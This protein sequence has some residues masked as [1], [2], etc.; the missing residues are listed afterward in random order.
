MPSSVARQGEPPSLLI[1]RSRTFV[2]RGVGRADYQHAETRPHAEQEEQLPD[3]LDDD[4]RLAGP[5]RPL[6]QRQV[7]TVHGHRDRTPFASDRFSEVPTAGRELDHAREL[8]RIDQRRAQGPE[9][10]RSRREG[11]LIVAGPTAPVPSS[12]RTP[13]MPRPP[14]ST[15]CSRD[16][17]GPVRGNIRPGSAACT[18]TGL[19][20][21]SGDDPHPAGVES[22]CRTSSASWGARSPASWRNLERREPGRPV[23]VVREP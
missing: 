19:P 13:R 4:L 1:S 10:A 20:V 6:D 18:V 21:G 7:R 12:G 22:Q 3:D 14:G 9:R 2:H 17:G 5:G 8:V 16:R 15:P 23:V 11:L